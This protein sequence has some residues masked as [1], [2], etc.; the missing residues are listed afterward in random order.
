MEI[1]SSLLLSIRKSW[2]PRKQASTSC[3][4]SLRT[5]TLKKNIHESHSIH[6]H[7][8]DERNRHGSNGHE[9]SSVIATHVAFSR[10]F[11]IVIAST[12]ER[13]WR[14]R[15]RDDRMLP[16]EKESLVPGPIAR[17]H[18]ATSQGKP[19]APPLPMI[20]APHCPHLPFP[21]HRFRSNERQQL[22]SNFIREFLLTV[23]LFGYGNY[24]NFVCNK[25]ILNI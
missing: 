24:G 18:V 11:S 20:L 3:S 8:I 5:I 19:R 13:E 7:A 10:V 14:A 12:N 16:A 22:D 21:K 4:R 25:I 15:P 2:R 17:Q 6:I 1:N 23:R 9:E